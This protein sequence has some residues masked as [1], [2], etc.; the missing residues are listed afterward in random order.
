MNSPELRAGATVEKTQF[1][2]HDLLLINLRGWW[3]ELGCR[4]LIQ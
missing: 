2:E 1:L 4:P 3:A